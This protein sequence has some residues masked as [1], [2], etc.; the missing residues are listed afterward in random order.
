MVVSAHLLFILQGSRHTVHVP[1]SI[2]TTRSLPPLLT[3]WNVAE[4]PSFLPRGLQ[5][6]IILDLGARVPVCCGSALR[7]WYPGRV[8][9]GVQDVASAALP[10]ISLRYAIILLCHRAHLATLPHIWLVIIGLV[11]LV[12]VRVIELVVLAT[13]SLGTALCARITFCHRAHLGLHGG[14]HRLVIIIEGA[15]P[16]SLTAHLSIARIIDYVLL[17]HGSL[18]EVGHRG[19][20]LDGVSF[21]EIGPILARL[22]ELSD[23]L[24]QRLLLFH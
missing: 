14:A 22:L 24:L 23:S 21:L 9:F 10:T 16:G 8:V 5:A 3:E 18:G 11:V 15:L 17:H 12:A 7:D 4:V 19:P 13:T 6:I 1:R 20:L 2:V